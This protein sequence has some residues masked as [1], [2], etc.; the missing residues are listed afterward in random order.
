MEFASAAVAVRRSIRL[1]EIPSPVKEYPA[2]AAGK[3]LW[4][5]VGAVALVVVAAVAL[6]R[7]FLKLREQPSTGGEIL[8]LV[9]MPGQQYAPAISP[10]GSQVAFTYSGGPHPGIYIAL[11]GGEK[12]LQLTPFSPLYICLRREGGRGLQDCSRCSQK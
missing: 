12:P 5:I 7:M 9:S 2:K 1:P 3:K 6:L 10:D 4:L 11:I 8:P